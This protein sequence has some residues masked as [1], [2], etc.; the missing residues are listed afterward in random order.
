MKSARSI[1]QKIKNTF[2]KV[3][4]ILGGPHTTMAWNKLIDEFLYDVIFLGEGE[5]TL[6]IIC[7]RLIEGDSVDDIQGIVTKST[8]TGNSNL[9]HHMIADL[10][11]LSF[12]EYD[13]FT[14]ISKE[15]IRTAYPLVTTRGCVYKCS[16]CSVPK[17]SGRRFRKRSP[18]NIIEELQWARKKYAVTS[19]EIIDDIFNLDIERCKTICLALIREN[20]GMTWSCPNG[21]R[22]DRIDKELAELMFKSGCRSVMVGIESADPIVLASV[23][24]GETID[25]IER[26]ICIFQD[27]GIT[28][29]GYFIVG[30]PGDSLESQ[31]RSV[32]FAKELGISAHFNMLMPYPGTELWHWAETNA[33]FL[34]E[35]EDGLHFADDSDKVNIVIETDDFTASERRH[36]YEMVHTMLGRF[37]MLIPAN[38]SRWQYHR[39][40]LGMLWNYD[41]P[42]LFTYINQL[43]SRMMKGLK[44]KKLS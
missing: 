17:I 3:P 43:L 30:L 21:V 10:D 37:D 39:R 26:G 22:A 1:S 24:K 8:V 36:A 14:Q 38:S 29:G 32:E 40:M 7:K 5:Q 23:N 19:F 44:W 2:P 11:M 16:Y 6:P 34:R 18:D 28:V 15:F 27:A 35:S 42:Q 9:S 20:V 41:R 13:L 12:P 33:R 4:L 31:K 25:D